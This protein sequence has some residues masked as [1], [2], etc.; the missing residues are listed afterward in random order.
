ML[1]RLA[2]LQA[3]GIVERCDHDIRVATSARHRVRT[4]ASAFDA[5]LDAPARTFSRAV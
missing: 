4:V 1:P 2:A 3:D 5:Y